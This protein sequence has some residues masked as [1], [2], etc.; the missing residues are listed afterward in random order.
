MVIYMQQA[1][2][3][4]PA[5]I[6][7]LDPTEIDLYDNNEPTEYLNKLDDKIGDVIDFDTHIENLSAMAVVNGKYVGIGFDHQQAAERTLKE[8]KELPYTLSRG[9]VDLHNKI[10]FLITYT[11]NSESGIIRM[12]RKRCRRSLPDNGEPVIDFNK[13]A[14]VA[15]RQYN[16]NKIYALGVPNGNQ[17]TRLAKRLY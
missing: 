6:R 10:G 2:M 11:F 7:L 9:F 13:I 5:E 15:K 4:N 12:L 8:L 16:L 3:V 17:I 14:E 1:R